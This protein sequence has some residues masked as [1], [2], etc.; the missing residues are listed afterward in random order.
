MRSTRP[1]PLQPRSQ[2]VPA[3]LQ[4]PVPDRR[5]AALDRIGPPMLWWRRRASRSQGRARGEDCGQPR[6][7]IPLTP[8][9]KVDMI[10]A[11]CVSMSI[12]G[13]VRCRLGPMHVVYAV[14]CCCSRTASSGQKRTSVN[15]CKTSPRENKREHTFPKHP[16]QEIRYIVRTEL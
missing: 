6:G 4:V 13:A 2:I 8:S 1:F 5:R 3:R 11:R 7:R 15:T 12:P 10:P 14:L 9:R 16:H